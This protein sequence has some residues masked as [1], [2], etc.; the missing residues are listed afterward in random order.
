MEPWLTPDESNVSPRKADLLKGLDQVLYWL[1]TYLQDL[2]DEALGWTPAPDVPPIGARLQHIAG[3]SRRLATYALE[4]DYDLLEQGPHRRG[5]RAGSGLKRP[6][7][8]SSSL[9]PFL[10]QG[11]Q[12]PALGVGR[13]RPLPEV[14]RQGP[15]G[16]P[17]QAGPAEGRRPGVR[18]GGPHRA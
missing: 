11:G 5:C 14:R 15:P 6:R 9:G 2:S 8:A 1:D 16:R 12:R 4:D 7:S 10:Q 13:S 17:R 3:A 18:E